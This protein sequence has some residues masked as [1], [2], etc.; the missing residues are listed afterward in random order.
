MS[1]KPTMETPII[2]KILILIIANIC[3][4]F[5]LCEIP[6]YGHICLLFVYL[7]SRPQRS[8]SLC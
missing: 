4:V 7:Y 2:R 8:F 3:S 5:A 1:T 6:F